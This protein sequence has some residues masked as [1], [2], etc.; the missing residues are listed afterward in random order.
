MITDGNG[1]T[2][3]WG[4]VVDRSVVEWPP[5]GVD[6]CELERVFTISTIFKGDTKQP[7]FDCNLGEIV[8]ERIVLIKIK[9][10][11]I[12]YTS[13]I[14]NF[15]YINYHQL[16]ALFSDFIRFTPFKLLYYWVAIDYNDQQ[17]N[18][19]KGGKR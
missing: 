11:V 4:E 5:I 1:E 15:L 3:L 12:S 6:P 13:T 9:G 2:L 17:F 8:R 10:L 7:I 16:R 14:S 18:Q 19:N